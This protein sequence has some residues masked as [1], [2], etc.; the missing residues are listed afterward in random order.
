MKD[1]IIDFNTSNMKSFLRVVTFMTMSVQWLAHKANVEYIFS[2]MNIEWTKEWNKLYVTTKEAVLQYKW[3]IDYNCKEFYK[4][5]L[6][7]KEL[8][9]SDHQG[10][11]IKESVI[12]LRNLSFIWDEQLIIFN[13][14]N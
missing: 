8:L 2:L 4:Q 3:N 13:L 14:M 12:Q 6:Q 9:K 10:N 7:N 5:I 11:I 1:G